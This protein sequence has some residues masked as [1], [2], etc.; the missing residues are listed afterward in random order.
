MSVLNYT[1]GNVMDRAAVLNNDSARAVYT[2]LVQIPYL[3]LAIDELQ[4]LFQLSN[5]PATNETSTEI[6]VPAGVTE[7]VFSATL[8][9]PSLPIDLIEP[10]NLYEKTY[11]ATQF[12]PMGKVN[13]LPPSD[14][15]TFSKFSSWSWIDQEIRFPAASPDINVIKMDYV[16]NLFVDVVDENSVIG[17]LNA[18][19][20]LEYRSAALLAEFIGENKTRADALNNNAGLGMDRVIGIGT[21]T[22][23]SFVVRRRPF[24]AAYKRRGA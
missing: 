8:P 21:K 1:A 14:G 3:N 16:K 7:I 18:K 22:K 12:S 19:S 2:Y 15:T 24:R 4:E 6:T 17:I 11:G 23:Q 5:I 13:I 20:F 10:R 9:N